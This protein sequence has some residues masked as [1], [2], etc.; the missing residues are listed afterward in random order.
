MSSLVADLFCALS[1]TFEVASPTFPFSSVNEILNSLPK[2]ALTLQSSG[3][4]FS[5]KSVALSFDL[6]CDGASKVIISGPL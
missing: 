4:F 6:V 3:I 1:T 5:G 2:S